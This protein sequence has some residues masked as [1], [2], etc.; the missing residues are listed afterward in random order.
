M[1]ESRFDIRWI[2]IL[3]PQMK[4]WGWYIDRDRRN[5]KHGWGLRES[6][7]FWATCHKTI[8]IKKH[9][10]TPWAMD[11]I[12]QRKK[13]NSYNQLEEVDLIQL[14]PSFHAELSDRMVFMTLTGEL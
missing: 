9:V 8:S 3:E 6:F 13:S 4:I 1:K 12:V 11:K 10:F 5:N 14:W 7:C 2:G